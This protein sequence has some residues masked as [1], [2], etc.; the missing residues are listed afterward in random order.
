MFSRIASRLPFSN[1]LLLIPMNSNPT[2][3]EALVNAVALPHVYTQAEMIRTLRR[4]HGDIMLSA[5]QLKEKH[6]FRSEMHF[7]NLNVGLPTL[8]EELRKGYA[9]LLND[10]ENSEGC[11]V[12]L[13]QL[14]HFKPAFGDGEKLQRQG[15]GAVDGSV[16]SSLENARRLCVYL[17][18]LAVELMESRNAPGIVFLI[19]LENC[20]LVNLETKMFRDILQ[21]CKKWY[22]EVVKQ[23][24]VLHGSAFTKVLSIFLSKLLGKRTQER[25]RVISDVR[26]LNMI[27]PLT[28][29]PQC[30]GGNYM[31]MHPCIWMKKQADVEDVD[32]DEEEDIGYGLEENEMELNESLNGMEYANVSAVDVCEMRNSILRG[33][34]MRKKMDGVWIQHFAVLRP[35][36]LLLYEKVSSRRP[37]IIVPIN[38]E[39]QVMTVL[40]HDKMKGCGFR[41]DIPGVIGGHILVATSEQ[42]R[43]NWLQELQWAI[44]KNQEKVK[45]REEQEERRAKIHRDFQSLDMINFDVELPIAQTLPMQCNNSQSSIFPQQLLSMEFPAHCPQQTLQNMDNLQQRTMLMQQQMRVGTY[46]QGIQQSNM[47]MKMQSSLPINV[48]QGTINIDHQSIQQQSFPSGQQGMTIPVSS[49]SHFELK[50]LQEQLLS[51]FRT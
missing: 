27:L 14:Q 35:E 18:D 15:H 4:N 29:I 50:S 31:M 2:P 1:N 11:V 38:Y 34:L 17:M 16:E 3:L 40:L 36:V 22:P 46:A 13:L 49:G 39:V 33:S 28:A 25:L 42:E 12:L 48:Q 37:I 20:S 41:I 19:D 9:H 45:Q 6:A 10:P 47:S 44:N 23:I 21:L 7:L 26:E 30:Y 8:Q 51:N 5:F 32:L 43:G 24:L